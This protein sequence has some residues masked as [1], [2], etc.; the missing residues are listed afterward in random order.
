LLWKLYVAA[1]TLR[2]WAFWVFDSILF[3]IS[4]TSFGSCRS[5]AS[6]PLGRNWITRRVGWCVVLGCGGG[7]SCVVG[8]FPFGFGFGGPW[9]DVCGSAFATV[10]ARFFGGGGGRG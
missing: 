5:F 7:F 6:I 1:T 2:C 10:W 3:T 9:F 8:T 4:I